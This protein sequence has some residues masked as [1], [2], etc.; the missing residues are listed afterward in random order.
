[1]VMIFRLK[2]N[3]SCGSIAHKL[4]SRVL[5]GKARNPAA[6]KNPRFLQNSPRFGLELCILTFKTIL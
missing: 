3:A 2:T 1:M 4:V 6:A 5:Q